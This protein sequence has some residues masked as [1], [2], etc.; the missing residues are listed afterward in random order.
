MMNFALL[1][2]KILSENPVLTDKIAASTQL[3]A[4]LVPDLFADTLR[5]LHLA[6]TCNEPLTPPI[7]ID[8]AWHEFILFTRLYAAFC[9]EHWGRFI[10]HNPGGDDKD[11]KHFF[12][13]THYQYQK[14]FGHK[15]N[16]QFWGN[17]LAEI[18]DNS[19]CGVDS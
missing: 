10:H 18:A 5:F 2:Q 19:D 17:V 3:S 4:D 6:V 9:Q 12:K 11:N 14:A 1:S 7:V 16:P 13:R 8:L 15:P